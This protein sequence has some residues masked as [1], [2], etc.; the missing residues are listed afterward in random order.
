VAFTEIDN[1]LK[2]KHRG[3]KLVVEKN[4]LQRLKI[5]H[6]AVVKELTPFIASQLFEACSI[7]VMEQ[8]NTSA[9]GARI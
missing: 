6:P 9:F 1:L 3:N 4:A 2:R 8:K 5:Q 7:L